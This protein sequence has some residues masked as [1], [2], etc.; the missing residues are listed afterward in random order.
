MRPIRI[1][2]LVILRHLRCEEAACD[3]MQERGFD[4]SEWQ[5]DIPLLP[6]KEFRK[7]E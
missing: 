1:T 2:N 3:S 7:R 6:P 5:T 4:W